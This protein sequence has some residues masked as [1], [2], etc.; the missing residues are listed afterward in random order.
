MTTTR[1]VR[2]SSPRWEIARRVHIAKTRWTRLRGLLARPPLGPGEGLLIVPCRAVHTWGMRY[3]IDVAFLDADGRVVAAYHRVEPGRRT[4]WHGEAHQALELPA[5]TLART[6][7]EPGDLLVCS[8]DQVS[9]LPA[10]AEAG[11]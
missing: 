7:T 10:V 6:W 11:A 2:L 8:P 4:P 9:S 3:P 5:G 1:V